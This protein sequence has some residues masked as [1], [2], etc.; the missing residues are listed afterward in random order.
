LKQFYEADLSKTTLPVN[1]GDFDYLLLLDI[2][3]HLTSPEAFMDTLRLSC[4]GSSGTRVII[5]TGNVAFLITRMMLFLGYFHYGARGILDLTHTRLFTFATL[6]NL[7]AQSG[8]H[9]E[10]VHGVPAPF[11]LVLGGGRMSR[12]LLGLNRLLIKLNKGLFSYQIFVVA[13][14]LPSLEWLL[15]EA[16]QAA[17]APPEPIADYST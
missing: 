10:R 6:R 17:E 16:R 9:I 14:P 12:L 4:R 7:L 2:V 1:T 11:P 3:E 8:Y 15:H 5:S 13:R